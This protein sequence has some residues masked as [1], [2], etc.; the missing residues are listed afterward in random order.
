MVTILLS[1][2]RYV[3]AQF[4]YTR[5]PGT[6]S[7]IAFGE[8]VDRKFVINNI[9]WQNINREARETQGEGLGMR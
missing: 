5:R 8:E 4:E 2:L 9:S 1:R 3:D 6:T 7:I